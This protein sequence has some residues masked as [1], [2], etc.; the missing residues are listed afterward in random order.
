MSF[1]KG[2]MRKVTYDPDNDGVIAVAQTEADMKKSVYDPNEDGV[3]DAYNVL[4][5]GGRTATL[6][7]AASDSSEKVKAQADYVCDGVDDQ[8]E[9]Q[10]AIDALPTGGTLGGT[11]Q[12]LEGTF[13]IS[14]P[15]KLRTY[16]R[17]Q[18]MH[19]GAT[20]IKL[21]DNANCNGLEYI[22]DVGG[23]MITIARMTLAGN[24]DN[25]VSGKGIYINT[26]SGAVLR[27]FHLDEVFVSSWA[28]EGIYTN[29]S[30]GFKLTRS[31]IEFNGGAGIKIDGS[32]QGFITNC[33][34][35]GNLH[36]IWLL[37]HSGGKYIGNLISGNK[38]Y[39]IYSQSGIREL[40]M[41]NS[42]LGNSAD[43]TH[44]SS[45]ILLSGSDYSIIIGNLFDGQDNE[46]WGVQIYSSTDGAV[47]MD[48]TFYR[49]WSA[50]IIDNSTSTQCYMRYSDLFMDCLAA[51]TNYVHSAITG[52]GAEQEITTGI[53]NPDVPRNISITTTNNASPSGD[54][55][56]TGVDARGNSVTENITI[57]PGG[58]AY[59]NVAFATVS[60]ITI[61]AGVSASD[62]VEVG[63]SDKL[64]L[65]NVI[66]ESGDVYKV[67]K[68]NADATIG[69][70]NPTYG[71]VDCATINA[72]DDFTIYYKSNL[73]IIS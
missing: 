24:K 13:V 72:G 10:A 34:I 60:K 66:Y 57:V 53:T 46:R 11:V 55:T 21:A 15:I 47:V 23:I 35:H 59:G 68:N 71:T 54:V 38:K 45:G 49:H 62:T 5:H 17:L 58:T 37:N 19:Q 28:E 31:W 69:T 61:P 36:G 7:V 48:N 20:T 65:S 12:L 56:I 44:T 9:I 8:V 1:K 6:V 40:Y 29:N 43:P 22:S 63:I 27:D 50:P 32:T 39:G 2:I 18:G 3:F 42:I 30:T 25:N 67:K 33:V 73:N 16:M 70:V 26:T 14:A 51:S 64:G 4:E 41:G 52:T